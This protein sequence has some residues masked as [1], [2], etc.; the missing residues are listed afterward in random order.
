MDS[1]DRHGGDYRK[2]VTGKLATYFPILQESLRQLRSIAEVD[3]ERTPP[4][5]VRKSALLKNRR[6]PLFTRNTVGNNASLS[7]CLVL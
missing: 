4:G 5:V 1:I 3:A 7:H 6:S 2:T